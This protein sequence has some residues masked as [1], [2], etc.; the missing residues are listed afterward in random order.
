MISQAPNQVAT[1]RCGGCQMTLMYPYGAPSVKC[2]VCQYITNVGANSDTHSQTVVVE[3]PMSF[4]GSGK[5]VSNVVVGVT[6]EKK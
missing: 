5:L 6:T 4:D 3:N 1:V 2:A